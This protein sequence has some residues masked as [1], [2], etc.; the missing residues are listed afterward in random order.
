MINDKNAWKKPLTK[1]NM[2]SC[3]LC[4]RELLLWF[5]LLEAFIDYLCSQ[6]WLGSDLFSGLCFSKHRWEFYDTVC[7][8]KWQRFPL[9][10]AKPAGAIRKLIRYLELH[11]GLQCKVYR[12]IWRVMFLSVCNGQIVLHFSWFNSSTDSPSTLQNQLLYWSITN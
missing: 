6:T 10:E 2:S 12:E 4:R 7:I 5:T 8:C 3:V 11:N 9:S 1:H